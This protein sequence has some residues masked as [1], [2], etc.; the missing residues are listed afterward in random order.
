MFKRKIYCLT[1]PLLKENMF[2]VCLKYVLLN[3]WLC[4][5]YISINI[6]SLRFFFKG[7]TRDD[8][9]RVLLT[10]WMEAAE[11]ET[12]KQL[13]LST[14]T[15]LSIH[16]NKAPF[17]HQCYMLKLQY[18]VYP[19]SVHTRH[20]LAWATKTFTPTP[21]RKGAPRK[22]VPSKWFVVI[23]HCVWILT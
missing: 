19:L 5:R 12:A 17:H 20:K 1:L 14:S 22:I 4:I 6:H 11:I 8:E 9:G 7:C 23:C 10:A 16:G 15:I 13:I 2:S 18:S 21:L 3:K